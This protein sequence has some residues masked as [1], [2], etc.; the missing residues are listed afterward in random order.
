[1]TA[2]GWATALTALGEEEGFAIA[3]RE[4]LIALFQLRQDDGSF[5]QKP[6]S[7]FLARFGE[8]TR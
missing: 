6:T 7:A 1:M 4:G 5:I 8:A 3:E 2:D